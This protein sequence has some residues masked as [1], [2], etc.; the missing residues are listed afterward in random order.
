[1]KIVGFL[2]FCA[3]IFC[4]ECY[5]ILHYILHYIPIILGTVHGQ[6]YALDSNGTI[7]ILGGTNINVYNGL[8][9][10]SDSTN[11]EKF[12]QTYEKLY[13]F[14]DG[15]V[16][17]GQ[18]LKSTKYS[19]LFTF[20]EDTHSMQCSGLDSF[21]LSITTPWVSGKANYEYAKS[22]SHTNGTVKSYLTTRY[23]CEKASFSNSIDQLIIEDS[24][25]TALRGAV[26]DSEDSING[27]EYL[28]NV[29]NRYGWHI[30]HEYTLG[31]T[32]YSTKIEE[33]NNFEDAETESRKFGAEFNAE[34]MRYGAGGGYSNS[35]SSETITMHTEKRNEMKFL[36][37]GGS[38]FGK[39]NLNQWT[40][41]L[42]DP[43][44]WKIIGFASL[45]PSLILLH[46][47]DDALLQHCLHLLR[48]FHD[49]ASVKHMRKTIDVGEYQRKIV[50]Q[51]GPY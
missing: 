2:A 36:Q 24:F 7:S 20:T 47:R 22:K 14:V 35:K 50:Q 23:V 28:V 17:H 33:V 1:M 46:D 18:M 38:V 8:S 34:F 25:F 11:V 15:Y 21:S 19:E 13:K 12:T 43:T 31:G 51:L 44:N 37:I 48:K 27:Y 40:D 39:D 32:I 49:Y 26:I 30:P 3:L 42:E 4:S 41:S 16:P 29:L 45:H 6:N 10:R 9:F 5:Q